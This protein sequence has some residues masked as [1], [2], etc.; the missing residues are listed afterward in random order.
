M[1]KLEGRKHKRKAEMSIK[2]SIEKFDKIPSCGISDLYP[3][4]SF[5]LPFSLSLSLS[6]KSD[7]L[8]LIPQPVKSI[9]T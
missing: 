5:P 3:L 4:L 8:P 2:L 9:R 1:R 6:P 7:C